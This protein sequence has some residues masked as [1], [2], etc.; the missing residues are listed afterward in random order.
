MQYLNIMSSNKSKSLVPALDKAMDILE[1]LAQSETPLSMA[2][3]A[4]LTNRTVSEIQ[5]TLNHLA[6]NHYIV[7]NKDGDYALGIKLNQFLL[8]K[9]FMNNLVVVAQP[10]LK[11]F[12]VITGESVHIS[13]WNNYRIQILTQE[14]GRGLGNFTL[15]IGAELPI[16]SSVSGRLIY[17][18]LSQEERNVLL[19]NQYILDANLLP[20]A[21][22]LEKI[23]KDKHYFYRVMCMKVFMT[24]GFP[25][26]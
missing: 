15:T 5:R 7:R 9:G 16:E 23:K 3:I 8:Q 25:Y 10:H 14:M 24:W 6:Q 17:T 19:D 21:K 18:F 11:N 12:S 4:R 20:N 13:A 26:S 1:L 22:G 2:Q